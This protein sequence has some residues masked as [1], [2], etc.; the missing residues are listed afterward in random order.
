ML[1]A[2]E[3][4]CAPGEVI[5]QDG[6]RHIL[7]LSNFISCPSVLYVVHKH[8]RQNN[9]SFLPHDRELDKNYLKDCQLI[10]HLEFKVV[11]LFPGPV[12]R[13]VQ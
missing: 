5:C 7:D 13:L 8:Q 2:G 9:K 1:T 12:D 6:G 3:K 4:P 10:R 11:F